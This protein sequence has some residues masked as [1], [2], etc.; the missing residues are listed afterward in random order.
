MSEDAA[1]AAVPSPAQPMELPRSGTEA[2]AN[3]RVTGELPE[4]TQP[5]PA[6]AAPAD[7]PKEATSESAPDPESGKPK[8]ETRR[9]P[10]A[11]ARIAEL[12]AKAR[13]LEKDLEEARK[14]KEAKADPPPARQPEHTRPKPKPDDQVD[15]KPKYASYEDYVEELA[16]W[17]AEQRMAARER[18][19][20]QAQDRKSVV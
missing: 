11:E 15:G 7:K 12:T 4:K 16:D 8:Q 17:K 20:T 5:K 19:Q 10:D 9:K 3:W 2:Y 6:D 14:P 1:V 13:Q 18:E